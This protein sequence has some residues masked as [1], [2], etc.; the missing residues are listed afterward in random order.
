MLLG[1]AEGPVTLCYI[2]SVCFLRAKGALTARLFCAQSDN[3][4]VQGWTRQALQR[5]PVPIHKC[6]SNVNIGSGSSAPQ[7]L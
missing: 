6:Y 2:S 5:E 1:I 3:L 7:Q 4:S